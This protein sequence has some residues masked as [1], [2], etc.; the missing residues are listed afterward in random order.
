MLLRWKKLPKTERCSLVFLAFGT[1]VLFIFSLPVVASNMAQHLEHYYLTDDQA[2]L[3]SADVVVVLA[4]GLKRGKGSVVDELTGLTYAR[5]AA[6]VRAFKS[7]KARLIVMSGGSGDPQDTRMVKLMRSLAMEMGVPADR[8]RIDPLSRNTLEHPVNLLKLG[9]IS[10]ADKIG[11]VT[12]AWHLPRAMEEFKRY[13][14]N[15]VAIP[16]DYLGA[17]SRKG[18]LAFIPSVGAL[19]NS[20]TILHE[21]IGRLW[22]RIKHGS[23]LN[24]AK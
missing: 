14:P 16:C 4:G 6:G 11:V 12:S 24:M 1:A 5:V 9:G 3:H 8:I 15:C 7:S 17:G 19:E 22:Y 18:L 21:Y 10:S 20:T 2:A 23:K 13:F